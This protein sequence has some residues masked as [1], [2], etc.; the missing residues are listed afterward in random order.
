VEISSFFVAENYFV[1]G[2]F[3]GDKGLLFQTLFILWQFPP[4]SQSMVLP[5]L[6]KN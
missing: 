6:R 4:I 5:K 1:S 2:S 3:F